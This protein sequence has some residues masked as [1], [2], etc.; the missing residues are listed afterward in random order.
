[1]NRTN[2]FPLPLLHAE[3]CL[4]MPPSDTDVLYQMVKRTEM[5]PAD[6][7]DASTHTIEVTVHW[8]STV[9][10]V[11]HL[12]SGQDFV[13]TSAIPRLPSPALRMVPGLTAGAMAMLAG[14]GLAGPM[15]GAVASIGAL[16]SVVSLGAG[17]LAQRSND[18][19]RDDLTR[20][21][22]DATMLPADGDIPVVSDDGDTACFV[23]PKGC[24]G[25][26]EMDGVRQGLDVLIAEG[27]ARESSLAPGAHE[28]AIVQG[29]RYR[30]EIAGLS[31]TAR[32]VHRARN[33]GGRTRREPA[34][35]GAS[36]GAAV[37]VA[38]VLGTMLFS[39][40]GASG[41]LSAEDSDATMADLRAFVRNQ[42]ERELTELPTVSSATGATGAAH[43]GAAGALGSRTSTEHGHRYEIQRRDPAPHLA[44]EVSAREA[45]A[46]RGIF[47]AMGAHA[48]PTAAGGILASP[49]AAMTTASG[50]GQRDANG[51]MNGT[52]V[53]DS[54]GYGGLDTVGTGWAGGGDAQ[55]TIG[56]GRFGTQGH[57]NCPP[58]SDCAYGQ[59]HG[60]LR[61]PSRENHGPLIHPQ[62]PS[63]E[64]GISADVIRRVVLRNLGQVNHCYEQGL[65]TNPALT[66]RV[67]VRFVITGGGS[68]LAASVA[69]DNLGAPAVAQCIASAVHRWTFPVPDA[70][71][72]IT[73][74]YPFSLMPAE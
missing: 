10:H 19:A 74:T 55:G 39:A 35:L 50:E 31:V 45:V 4:P 43:E 9:L 38:S 48:M 37:A 34:L 71:G 53:G 1:M 60:I 33:F 18:E 32:S 15:A 21:V 73:V 61:A 64:G 7:D 11:A 24:R 27:Y 29:G 16:V 5:N 68:V 25:E 30:V 46:T 12:V 36:V 42:T 44:R 6:I 62:A 28:V 3:T 49:F 58:G 17:V 20:F 23:F 66:G 51:N 67:S 22:V 57:G 47:M 59:G 63:V 41:W 65:E 14:A 72:P 52:D 56:T 26:V 8:R 54:E 69:E 70:S 2:R 40:G 13:L